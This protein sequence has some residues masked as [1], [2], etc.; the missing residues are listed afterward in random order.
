MRIA[1]QEMVGCY[2]KLIRNTLT[3]L[4]FFILCPSPVFSQTIAATDDL[5]FK[6]ELK[7]CPQRIVSLAPNLTEIL[8]ALG[9]NNQLVGVTRF[10][11]YP[12]EARTKTTVGGLVDPSLEI[13]QALKPDLV[14]AFRGNPRNLIERLR[15]LSL[16]V[17]AFEQGHSFEELFLLIERIGKL[18]CR[19]KAAEELVK[20]MKQDI[21]A[22]EMVVARRASGRK[23]FLTIH[24]QGNGLWT[25][26]RES[27]LNY[28][29]EKAGV[30]N[31]ASDAPGN[32][33]AITQEEIIAGNPDIILILA[34]DE[35]A[36][37]RA[38]QSILSRP[39]FRNIEAVRQGKIFFLEENIF[40]RFGP[41]LVE[42]YR[43]LVHV[44]HP[45]LFEPRG[46][47]SI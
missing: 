43:L 42:A 35:E 40:S 6:L 5:G 21:S 22:T 36:F 13:I 10:C 3:I 46:R 33:L 17:F 39:A 14:L 20:K 30:K 12:P 18:T 32:W 27:F 28:L 25:C 47:S 16:P 8:F 1:G 11:D 41:R 15:S 26:G 34:R 29:L 31:I 19:E 38:R 2:D 24:G 4:L 45:E 7:T 37:R 44:L 9:L 23:V